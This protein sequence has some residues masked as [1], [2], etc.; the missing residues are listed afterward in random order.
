MKKLLMLMLVLVFALTGCGSSESEK[1]SG[2]EKPAATEKT[3]EKDNKKLVE[4]YF[5]EIN[6]HFTAIQDFGIAFDALRTSSAN[7]EIDNATFGERIY[8]DLVPVAVDLVA[9]V[10]AVK[11]PTDEVKGIHEKIISMLNKNHQALLEIV[12]G[13]NANDMSK[14]TEANEIL[15]DARK[16]E[17]EVV[18][19]STKLAEKYG[20]K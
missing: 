8:T 9:K 2:N 15:A 17:R 10:E 20:I 12:A 16:L 14:I 13:V 6:T 18:E 3:S 7:G 19:E 4:S 5:K 1:S 11:V